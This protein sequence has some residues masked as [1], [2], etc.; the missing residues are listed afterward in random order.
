MRL[1]RQ[2][3]LIEKLKV[4][5]TLPALMRGQVPLDGDP[6]GDNETETTVIAS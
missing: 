2:Q 5:V 6:K 3:R 4:K 1:A